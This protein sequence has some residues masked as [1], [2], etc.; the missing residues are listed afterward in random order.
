MAILGATGSGK[1]SLINLIPRFYDP[2]SGRITI[3]GVD[4]K[5]MTQSTLRAQIAVVPQT[6]LLFSGS[7]KKNILFG[8]ETEEEIMIGAAQMARIDDFIET[9]PKGYQT[10]VNQRG[11]NLSGGQ[12]Q[13]ISLARALVRKPP[14]LILDDS[15][16]AVDLKTEEAIQKALESREPRSTCLIV[17]QRIS[18]VRHAHNIIVLEEGRIAVQGTHK[19]L[20]KTSPL[21]RDI[22]LSQLDEKEVIA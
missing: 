19:E 1:S 12:K 13:R 5:E 6:P 9:L 17:A 20:W 16:S 22:C 7:V 11:V 15:T 18:S 14:I 21:Y 8:Q 3:G 10:D 4:I 2:Q